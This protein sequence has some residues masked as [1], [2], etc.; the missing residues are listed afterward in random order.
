MNLGTDIVYI[1]KLKKLMENERF[2]KKVFHKSEYKD[3]KAEHLAGIFAAK[4]AFFKAINKK[5][6]WLK[7]EIKKQKTHKPILINEL[8]AE[9]IDVSISHDKDYAI[10]TVLVNNVK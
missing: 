3:Y 7:V 10:A 5:P 9:I 4:E 1:P 6:D 2:M 8:K